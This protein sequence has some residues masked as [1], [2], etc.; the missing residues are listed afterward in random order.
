M[1]RKFNAHWVS[2]Q[3]NQLSVF[4]K[5]TV[6]M[7][8]S[9]ERTSLSFENCPWSITCA[10]YICTFISTRGKSLLDFGLPLFFPADSHP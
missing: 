7:L 5:I 2:M 6:L 4:E 1:Y 8:S 9:D 10:T 3:E